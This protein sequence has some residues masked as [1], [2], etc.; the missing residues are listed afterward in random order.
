M[1]DQNS[2]IA[3]R[4]CCLSVFFFFCFGAVFLSVLYSQQTEYSLEEVKK[5]YQSIEKIENEQGETNS[6]GLRRV[7]VTESEF[8]SYVAYRIENEQEELMK[9]LEFKFLNDNRLECKVYFDL[10]GQDLP[11][12]IR[13][14]MTFYFSGNL[15]SRNG[16]VRLNLDDLFLEGQKIQPLILDIVLLIAAKV[17]KTPASRIDDWYEIPYGIT[18]IKI[19]KGRA[20]FYY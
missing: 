8:N 3:A 11:K 1:S 16:S 17:N 13:P 4:I 6:S 7:E 20:E 5:V 18:D 12:L 19:H 14:E 15:E 2:S 10:R 9:E